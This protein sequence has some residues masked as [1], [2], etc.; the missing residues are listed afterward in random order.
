MR[1]QLEIMKS[2]DDESL[3]AWANRDSSLYPRTGLLATSPAAF[4]GSGY[5]LTGPSR[6]KTPYSMTN[7]GLHISLML[8][9]VFEALERGILI[10]SLLNDPWFN[11]KREDDFVAP[12]TCKIQ[13]KIPGQHVSTGQHNVILR[14]GKASEGNGSIS[15]TRIFSDRLEHCPSD[16]VPSQLLEHQIFIPQPRYLQRPNLEKI[17]SKFTIRAEHSFG[18]DFGFSSYIGDSRQLNYSRIKMGGPTDKVDPE[19]EPIIDIVLQSYLIRP[20]QLFVEFKGLNG[21]RGLKEGFVLGIWGQLRAARL[22]VG[23][24]LL[25]PNRK[26]LREISNEARKL[27]PLSRDRDTLTFPSAHV[28]SAALRKQVDRNGE[29]MYVVDLDLK[30]L[31][32]DI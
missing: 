11:T 31:L 24:V 6:S 17:V 18:Y 21:P 32:G 7:K 13:P 16:A 2:S 25:A 12:L 15:Y 9:P 28:L 26:S 30:S 3:F 10:T 19:L 1:L 22:V 14:F 4:E 5:I 8:I 29:L 20:S 27:F 23:I